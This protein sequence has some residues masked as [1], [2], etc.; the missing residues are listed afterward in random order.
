M[1]LRTPRLWP[2][3]RSPGVRT[4]R[5]FAREPQEEVRY[6]GATEHAFGLAKKRA[7][8]GG[9]FGGVVIFI[10]YSAVAVVLWFGV[11]FVSQEILSAGDLVAFILY[12]LLVAFSLGVLSGL[13]GDLMKALGASER[14]FG[15]IDRVPAMRATG[16]ERTDPPEEASVGFYGVSFSYPTRPEARALEAVSFEIKPGA[17]VALVGASGS[18]KSTVAALLSRFYDPSEGEI[19]LGG[20]PITSWEPQQLRHWIGMVAQEP[21]LFSGTIRHNVQYGK[22]GAPD[23]EVW[24]AL[25]VA[26]AAGFVKDLPQGLE[27]EIGERGLRLSGGQK[28]RIAI[29]RAVLKDPRVLLLD[30]ATSALDVES[31]TLVQRALER[32]MQGRTTLI[33]AH[34][35]ST[36]QGADQIV[37]LGAGRVLEQ[38]SHH[39][40][41]SQP[42][43]H[44]RRL[45]TSQQFLS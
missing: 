5:S 40:L 15:L 20:R 27:T 17:R 4:V 24:Q 22:P 13:Y 30:E 41:M 11:Q 19:T 37:V 31:E 38:G 26:N 6:G 36:I 43:G 44:Y 23:E 14:V 7:W 8:L 33:I 39:D 9:V 1:P 34:R 12:T 29:A 16:R 45:V 32:L 42:Q 2:K 28:Q 21:V 35:L 25:K 18:G 10:G 3:R